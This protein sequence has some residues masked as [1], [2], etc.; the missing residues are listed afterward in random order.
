[1]ALELHGAHCPPDTRKRGCPSRQL[2]NFSLT[3]QARQCDARGVAEIEN[4]HCVSGWNQI[5]T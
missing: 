1:M 2:S 5:F 3:Y 4:L